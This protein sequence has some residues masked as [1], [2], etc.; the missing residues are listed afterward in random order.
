VQGRKDHLLGT[1]RDTGEMRREGLREVSDTGDSRTARGLVTRSVKARGY[2]DRRT[3][4][5]TRGE[6][7]E[8]TERMRVKTKAK[9]RAGVSKD[10]DEGEGKSKS[11]GRQLEV[12][13]Q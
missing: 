2:R 9:A 6:G 12:Q 3:T 10:G 5:T 1:R 11:E 8:K 4:H 7:R 13:R